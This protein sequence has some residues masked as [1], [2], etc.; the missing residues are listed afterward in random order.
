MLSGTLARNV[1]TPELVDLV[2]AGVSILVGTTDKNGRPE[3]TRA[4]GAR[5]LGDRASARIYLPCA[6]A[7]IAF[8]NLRAGGE[9]AVGFSRILD[10]LCIQLKGSCIDARR[11]A[12]DERPIV[13]RYLGAFT[14]QLHMVGVPRHLAKRLIVWPA[15]AVDFC[16]RDVFTQTPG[17][18]AGKRFEASR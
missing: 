8:E 2:E 3:A 5:V 12:D 15:Y 6:A 4:C 1:L 11:A 17:P 9:I 7:R 18:G 13:E 14:E 10:N 16:I